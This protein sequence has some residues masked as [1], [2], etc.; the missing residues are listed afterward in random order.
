[1]KRVICTMKS[2]LR[3]RVIVM[4]VSQSK[5]IQK[6]AIRDGRSHRGIELT[7]FDLA[8]VDHFLSR[9]SWSYKVSKVGQFLLIFCAIR[10]VKRMLISIL[11]PV[12]K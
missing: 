10:L 11:M 12:L 7:L 3:E 2:Y 5:L 4:V 8:Q 1:M 9:F 6:L